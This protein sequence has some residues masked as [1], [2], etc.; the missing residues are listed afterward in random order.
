MNTKS[1]KRKS[2]P[3]CKR[4]V[5]ALLAA[6]L[7]VAPVLCETLPAFADNV[8]ARA[9]VD[10]SLDLIE[11]INTVADD[12]WDA[13]TEDT[14]LD[15]LR[16]I[17]LQDRFFRYCADY[18]EGT[19]VSVP[20]D[21]SYTSG[22]YRYN[23]SELRSAS[24]YAPSNGSAIPTA[25]G[26]KS[27]PPSLVASSP[28]FT[29]NFWIES[30]YSASLSTFDYYGALSGSQSEYMVQWSGGSSGASKQFIV[31]LTNSSGKVFQSDN[32]LPNVYR[33]YGEYY[34]GVFMSETIPNFTRDNYNCFD[35][36]V[37]GGGVSGTLPAGDFNGDQPWNYYNDTLLPIINTYNVDTQYIVYPTGYTVPESPIYPTDFVTGI[38]KD[39]TIENPQLP[40]ASDLEFEH[41]EED[42]TGFH[43]I[44]EIKETV[45]II[46]AMD[47]WWWLTEKTLDS[48]NLKIF[49]VIFLTV[50]VLIF[51][52]WIIGQ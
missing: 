20:S 12:G 26:S 43:P 24:I 45:D 13:L 15:V 23:G 34:R 1:V 51:I 18:L 19:T 42:L 48:L 5:S 11:E 21:M 16:V 29:I 7:F 37:C 30:S 6:F 31:H 52:V 47:F 32:Y 3:L 25:L 9:F 44:Q 46:K 2:V 33:N 39:W 17:A 4:I 49:Y 28:D 36:A 40:T 35:S 10:G 41:Y 27:D 14:R 38:P 8:D 22:F 50:G